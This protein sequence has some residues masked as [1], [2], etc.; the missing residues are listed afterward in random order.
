MLLIPF[1]Y[2]FV[3]QIIYF[4]PLVRG[5]NLTI[6]LNKAYQSRLIIRVCVCLLNAQSSKVVHFFDVKLKF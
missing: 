6:Y 2:G 3:L 4:R 1:L 5:W